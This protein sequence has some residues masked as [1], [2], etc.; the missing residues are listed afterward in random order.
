MDIGRPQSNT[1]RLLIYTPRS[2]QLHLLPEFTN[3]QCFGTTSFHSLSA[4]DRFSSHHHLSA[5]FDHMN[6]PCATVATILGVINLYTS[7]LTLNCLKQHCSCNTRVNKTI[8]ERELPLD[9][10][11]DDRSG[12]NNP[13]ASLGT[14]ADSGVI[15]EQLA[16]LIAAGARS[17]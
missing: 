6:R 12:S 15:S 16:A 14:Q 7:P 17:D 4:L 8:A 11:P 1:P 5:F 2:I 13:I 9:S 3:E 10:I